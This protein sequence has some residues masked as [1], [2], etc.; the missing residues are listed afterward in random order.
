VDALAIDHVNFFWFQTL[1]LVL[2]AQERMRTP[3]MV[4]LLIERAP[5]VAE[6]KVKDATL[7]LST[8]NSMPRIILVRIQAP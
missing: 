7:T 3:D 2:Q 6:K 1:S 4:G 5:K 8:I